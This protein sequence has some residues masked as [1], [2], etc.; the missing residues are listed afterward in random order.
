[1]KNAKYL[2]EFKVRSKQVFLKMCFVEIHACL[3][4][5]IVV[6]ILGRRSRLV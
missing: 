2:E 3:K 5:N 4:Q 1:M 6:L